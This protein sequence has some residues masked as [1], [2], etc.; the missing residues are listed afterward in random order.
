M[1]YHIIVSI[2]IFLFLN[3]CNPDSNTNQNNSKKGLLKIEK[4]PNKQIKNKLLDDLKNLIETAN[5]DRKK[6]EKKLEEEPSNQYGISIF[7]E[8]YWVA[9]YET[10]ADN[11]D[12][13]KNYRKFIYAT[14]NP[15]NTN[16]LANLSKILIQSKQKTLLFGTFCNLGRTFDTA[17]NHLYPKKDALD[18]LEI[19]NLEKLKNSFEKLLSMKSIVSDML[20]QLLLDYQDDKDSIKTDIAKLES[21]LTELYKQIE[22]K[23]S[24]A[25]KLKNNIL[26]ISNL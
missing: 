11:T 1:K 26:S 14:L 25:T 18:K 20:N 21:H 5:E 22:K 3:A 4:I 23:S 16:K 15:I 6:Y 19:S 12:R 10:V 24:Q 17:I 13:S 8:I 7:K 9:S 2:F